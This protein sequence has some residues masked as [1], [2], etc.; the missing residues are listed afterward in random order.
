MLNWHP[1]CFFNSIDDSFNLVELGY[2]LWCHIFY[3]RCHI[4]F[5]S[6]FR[7]LRRV[8]LQFIV[9]EQWGSSIDVVLRASNFGPAFLVQ[10]SFTNS[11][12]SIVDY[13]HVVANRKIAVFEAPKPN[14][15]LGVDIHTPS[16]RYIIITDLAKVIFAVIFVFPG[17]N[18]IF[19]LPNIEA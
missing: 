15:I 8:L 16:L 4:L 14:T 5:G 11:K 17:L 1:S 7:F 12:L 2:L 3:H 19:L 9:P 10:V 18:L 6:T 13:T